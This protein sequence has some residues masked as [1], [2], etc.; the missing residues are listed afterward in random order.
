[1]KR[2]LAALLL[3]ASGAAFPASFLP[4]ESGSARAEPVLEFGAAPPA[5]IGGPIDLVD[6]RGQRF[7]NA[8][9]RGRPALLFFGLTHCGVSCPA[10][11]L[12]AKQLLALPAPAPGRSVVFV[13]LDPLNDDPAALRRFLA[14]FDERL[15]GLTGSPIQIGDMAERFGVGTRSVDGRLE[16]SAMWYLLDASGRVRRVYGSNTS[17]MQLAADLDR[18][19]QQHPGGLR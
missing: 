14:A 3:A 17:V 18:L 2:L 1:M 11:L 15:I 9:L 16:H 10:A 13:T 4:G 6:D 19:G 7:T 12:T 8:R 5:G